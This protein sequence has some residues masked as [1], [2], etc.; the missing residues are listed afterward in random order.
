[1]HNSSQNFGQYQTSILTL[2]IE[3]SVSGLNLYL[4][5]LLGNE[6]INLSFE[7]FDKYHMMLI[8]NIQ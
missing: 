4:G 6:D 3:T 8:I 5:Y 7:C 1:M 2:A